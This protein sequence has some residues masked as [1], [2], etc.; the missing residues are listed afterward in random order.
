MREERQYASPDIERLVLSHYM[1]TDS[2]IAVRLDYFQQEEARQLFLFIQ[3]HRSLANSFDEWWDLW[4]VDLQRVHKNL[5]PHKRFLQ[6]I[7]AEEEIDG[8]R[9]AFFVEQLRGFAE[10]REMR[11]VYTS[12]ITLFEAGKVTEARQ[13]LEDGVARLRREFAPEVLD[14][15]DF[16]ETFVE[17]YKGYKR[18]QKGEE[19]AKIPTGIHKL[20]RRVGGSS[21]ASLNFF[22]GESGSGKTFLLMEIAYRHCL[23]GRKVVFVTV[24]LQRY[25]IETRWDGRITGIDYLKVDSGNLTKSEELWWR[26]R[27]RDIHRAYRAGGRLATAFI[28]EGCT[29]ASLQ[30]EIDFWADHWGGKID[31]LVVDYADLMDTTR[32]VYSEQGEQGAVFRDLKRLSQTQNVVLW[33]GSQISGRS[34]G[35]KIMGLGETGYSMKKANWANLVLGIGADP[36]DIEEG[37]MRLYVAKNTFGKSGFEVMLHPDF[38]RAMVDT[39]AERSAKQKKERT[40][41]RKRNDTRRRGKRGKGNKK[42][43]NG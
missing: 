14:R 12:S 38:A 28:P 29:I 25:E 18:R 43:R 20:D 1:R 16:V 7:W 21:P 9:A 36:M 30:T 24:E 40:D 37:V 32:R 10:G 15:G 27:I 39:S 42:G 13:V 2:T 34:Y 3:A 17:R 31:T 5:S 41:G 26:K 19:Q 6:A 11:D 23:M 22:Q 4:K 8:G 33:T 35:K